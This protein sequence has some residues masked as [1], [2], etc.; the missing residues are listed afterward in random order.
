[1]RTEAQQIEALTRVQQALWDRH[2]QASTLYIQT[3]D[4]VALAL[5]A[6][7]Q[8][9]ALPSPGSQDQQIKELQ[10]RQKRIWNE[11]T[12]STDDVGIF[13]TGVVMS[14]DPGITTICIDN[15]GTISLVSGE[16]PEPNVVAPIDRHPTSGR[17]YG[18]DG[19]G[20][21]PDKSNMSLKQAV[22]WLMER[23]VRPA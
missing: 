10:A 9:M 4:V 8:A 19:W 18:Y 22:A 2:H 12:P 11:H 15:Q 7:P 13:R 16:A 23:P 6:A 20:D 5:G 14:G 1:M 21:G 17:P 3:G